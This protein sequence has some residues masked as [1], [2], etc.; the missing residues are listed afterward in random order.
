MRKYMDDVDIL[1]KSGIS[2]IWITSY[3]EEEVVND[4]RELVANNYKTMALHTWSVA[5]GMKH[6]ATIPGEK[7]GQ[8]NA[9]TRQPLAAL[10]IIAQTSGLRGTEGSRNIYI[11][12]DLQEFLTGQSSASIR[13]YIRDIK[14][15]A[16]TAQNVIICV[17]PSV[18]LPDDISKLFR[19]VEYGLPDEE[20][21]T[22]I[23]NAAAN[24]LAQLAKENDSYHE[25]SKADIEDAINAC[26]GMTKKEIAMALS[27]SIVRTKSID[28]S[29]LLT[30]KIQE[31]KK[32]GILDYKIPQVTLDDVGGN[33]ALKDWL[34]EQKE[35]FGSDAR[36]LG[37]EMPKGYVAVGVPGGAKTM[38]AEAFA[39][40][41]KIPLLSLSMAKIMSKHVGESERK[42]EYAMQVAKSCAPCVLL[43]DEVEKLV[44]GAGA[45]GSSNR[46]DG[47]VTNRVFA[48]LLKFMNDNTSGVYV[49]MTSNDI[50][51]LPPE[52]TR[53][54]RV[55]GIWYFGTP[56]KSDREDILRIHF[57]HY[58]KELPDNIMQQVVSETDGY[59]GAELKEVVK[60]CMRKAFVRSKTS[61]N[62]NVGFTSDD[63]MASVKEVIPISQSSREKI[64][65]LEAWCEGRARRSDYEE[66]KTV[67][68]ENDAPLFTSMFSMP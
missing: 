44:G 67:A 30:N 22:S 18:E 28:V 36:E 45:G 41:M 24:R 3:E 59:T 57:A 17:S 61:S 33:G 52:F 49:I 23:V 15:Y 64:M 51:S 21:V 32:S 56:T 10:E 19:I 58:S 25:A 55:D 4:I 16:T 39:G 20:D 5:E 46:T 7:N 66:A 37:L 12:R 60:N 14:E 48:S 34:Y 53:V 47:G 26:M 63:V 40:M 1:I 65:A 27:E 42:I 29:F 38:M 13:R 31:V 43:L 50:S 9:N 6:L 2:C 11:M 8:P 62:G 35:L 68:P 54:G